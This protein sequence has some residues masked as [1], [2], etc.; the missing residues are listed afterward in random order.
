MSLSIVAAKH[1]RILWALMVRGES[2]VQPATHSVDRLEQPT[3][4]GLAIN[5]K[6]ARALRLTIPQSLVQSAT[7][8][9]Q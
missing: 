2:S 4:L 3:Q 7:E 6:T 8:V 1:A 5:L 9:I